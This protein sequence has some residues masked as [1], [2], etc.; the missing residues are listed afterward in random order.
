MSQKT[1]FEIRADLL[2]QS[3]DFLMEQ[4]KANVEFAKSTFDVM[5]KEGQAIQ[6]EWMKHKPTFF[7]LDDIIKKAGELNDFVTSNRK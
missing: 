5:V 2:K 6:E 3:Q 1:P 7:T 4:Y